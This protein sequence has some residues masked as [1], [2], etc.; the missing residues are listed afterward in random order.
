L[1]LNR[2]IFPFIK[3]QKLLAVEVQINSKM[4]EKELL[5]LGRQKA[6]DSERT[7][8]HFIRTKNE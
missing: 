5:I 3:S 2:D 8:F 4:Q 6:L 7:N 1:Y